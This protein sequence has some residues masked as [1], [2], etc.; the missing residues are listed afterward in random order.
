MLNKLST[1][2]AAVAAGVATPAF[3]VADSLEQVI[4][5]RD[6]LVFP[7]IVKPLLSHKAKKKLGQKH[8]RVSNFGELVTALETERAAGIETLLMEWIPGPDDQLCSYYTYL[9]ESSQPL[10]DFTKRIIRRV[11][12]GMGPAC[13]HITDW[14][15]EIIEQGR[16]LFRHVGLRGLANVE[17][18]KDPRDGIYKLIECNARFTAANCL[19]AASGFDLSAFVYNRIVG[20]EQSPLVDF[21]RGMRLWD[22]ALDVLS[23]LALHREGQ[24]TFGQWIASLMH[25]QTLPYFDW[26][27]PLPALA[28]GKRLLKLMLKRRESGNKGAPVGGDGTISHSR[29]R[30][31]VQ[32]VGDDGTQTI[33]T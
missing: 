19:V 31:A 3:W 27:D 24:L 28:R 13:Y 8:L 4:S 12:P 21:K 10:F 7:L 17:F 32:R 23:F 30:A 6:E 14:V 22:P 20:L 33:L 9:D 25:R 26:K 5:H 1:Y 29:P 18:K 15:P 11:P 16:R 2:R